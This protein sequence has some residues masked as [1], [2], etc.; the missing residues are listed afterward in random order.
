LDYLNSELP[1]AEMPSL[2]EHLDECPQ[3]RQRIEEFEIILRDGPAVIAAEVFD[4]AVLDSVPWSIEQGEKRLYAA[5]GSETGVASPLR[6]VK[7]QMEPVLRGAPLTRLANFLTPSNLRTY[8]AV[9]ASL[10]L[11][12]A[13]GTSIY[14][15]GLMRGREQ[16]QIAGKSENK[17]DARLKAQVENL[18][19]ERAQIE[20]SLRER[21]NVISVLRAQLKEQRKQ[22]EELEGS[23]QSAKLQAEEQTG[24]ISS[25]RDELARKLEDGQGALAS[26]QKRIDA[27]QEAE[28]ND[29]VR[30]VSLE[31]QLQQLSQLAK[32]REGTIDEQQRLLAASRDIRDLMGERDLYFAEVYDV[33]T[34]GKK[35]KPYGRVFYTK[36][37]S[38]V[39]Y[40]YDLDQQ[41]GLKNASTF[42]AWGLRGPDRSTALSL[43]VMYLDNSSNKRWVLQFDDPKVLEQ[44]NAVFVTVE[45]KGGSRTPRGQQVLG[46]TYLREE[47][48]HP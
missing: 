31:N 1:V 7:D 35:K 8:C 12:I 33:G 22:T 48:N 36:G 19:H 4:E 46:A 43:G 9:A 38:L 41:P 45:P 23:L 21:E 20:A 11:L 16:S 3:C 27:L 32:E 47:P 17:N 5:I 24:G 29:A 15:I 42:Q 18:A 25:E 6:H 28:R 39:F 10:I 2:T 13:T 14:R 34:N 37:K 30:V 44:I 40:A 26:A